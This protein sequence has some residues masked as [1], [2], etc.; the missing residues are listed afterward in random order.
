MWHLKILVTYLLSKAFYE[1]V[2]AACGAQYVAYPTSEWA[3][4]GWV[5]RDIG[6][7]NRRQGHITGVIKS[8][9]DLLV[10]WGGTALRTDDVT[11][12]LGREANV[13]VFDTA[14][15]KQNWTTLTM[16]GA[17]SGGEC[18]H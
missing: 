10:S 15:L 14:A 8:D 9:A 6:A 18:S 2:A 1:L 4:S 5:S 17:W 7:G 13:S 16:I 11:D 12:V 3:S